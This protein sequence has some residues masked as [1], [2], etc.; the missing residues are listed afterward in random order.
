M[1][2]AAGQAPPTPRYGQHSIYE[3]PAFAYAPLM[4]D[5]RTGE[6]WAQ[7]LVRDLCDQIW[8]VRDYV[9]VQLENSSITCVGQTTIEYAGKIWTF[10][11]EGS[12]DMLCQLIDRRVMTA[13][14]YPDD[15]LDLEFEGA[16]YLRVRPDP[17]HPEWEVTYV[18]N[19][20]W[21]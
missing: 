15:S 9:M 18:Q 4:G 14:S 5:E 8:F 10:P 19:R 20:E 12:R 3:D 11:E 2:V 21:R 13:R 7:S 6:D 17:D 16:I 1:H